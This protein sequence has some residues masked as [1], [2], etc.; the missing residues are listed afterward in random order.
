VA[1]SQEYVNT[2]STR[3]VV[4]RD[5]SMTWVHRCPLSLSSNGVTNTNGVIA[6]PHLWAKGGGRGARLEAI[7]GPSMTWVHPLSPVPVQQQR[8]EDRTHHTAPS[9]GQRGR[10]RTYIIT[11][12]GS[13]VGRTLFLLIF[14]PQ[15]HLCCLVVCLCA[16]S[17]CFG[18]SYL[19]HPFKC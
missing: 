18:R 2:Y 6:L 5:A 16:V 10:I 14:L 15:Q 3:S 19:R 1:A 4:V 13:L 12:T 17:F 7:D 9:V 8:R 11:P